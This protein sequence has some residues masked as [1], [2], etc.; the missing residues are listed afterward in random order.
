MQL[1]QHLRK[2][3]GLVLTGIL[4]ASSFIA[5]KVALRLSLFYTKQMGD[6]LHTFL[7]RI[8]AT[9]RTGF[10]DAVLGTILFAPLKIARSAW[11]L[12][13]TASRPCKHQQLMEFSA[14]CGF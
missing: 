11:V 5:L 12:S 8:R 13:F 3:V 7:H 14:I 9:P 4:R 2:D 10:M 6:Y 1:I